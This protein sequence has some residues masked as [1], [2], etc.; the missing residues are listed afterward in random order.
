MIYR[1]LGKSGL[2][3]SAFGIGTSQCRSLEP[4]ECVQLIETAADA[5]VTYID[6]ARSYINGEM[7]IG[8]A[9]LETRR[10]LIVATKTGARLGNQCLRDLH[11]SLRAI[12][13][14]YVDVWMAH[15][16]RTE[17][18]YEAC[19]SLGGFFDIAQAAKQAGLVRA[20]GVSFHASTNLIQ[21][22]ISEGFLD[23]AMFQINIIERETVFGSSIRSYIS[24]LLPVAAKN[25][26]GVVAM[27][28][29]AGGELEHGSSA[30]QV[31]YPEYAFYES[32]IHFALSQ[33]VSVAVVG[34]RN[35]AQLKTNLSAL[36]SFCSRNNLRELSTR[37]LAVLDDMTCTRCGACLESCPNSIEI[38]KMFRLYDQHRLLGMKEVAIRKYQDLDI[39]GLNCTGCDECRKYCPE[40]LDISAD[41]RKIDL[42]MRSN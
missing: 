32:A 2:K 39:S 20:I 38:P 14:E 7:S 21:R 26:V 31:Q 29:L 27:K 5:G 22:A 13:R 3:V 19:K 42:I 34:S 11:H 1:T 8:M 33:D 40:N 4:A 30:I 6:T 37:R 17:D 24:Q 9:S 41:L 36:E 35:I 10:R 28:V 23:M 25:G 12:R 16:I 18:E 15:M